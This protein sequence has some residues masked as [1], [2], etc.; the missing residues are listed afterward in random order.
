MPRP[1]L[2]RDAQGNI[3]RAEVI[4]GDVLPQATPLRVPDLYTASIK[5]WN[6]ITTATG[7]TAVEAIANLKPEA[8]KGTAVLIVSKG[9]RSK[10]KILNNGQVFRL[11]AGSR[12]G[13]EITLKGVGMFFG[14]I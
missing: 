14:N 8:K 3:I 7:A 9:E 2:P 11:F 5:L 1:K 10:T 12:I 6:K 13:R 4:V